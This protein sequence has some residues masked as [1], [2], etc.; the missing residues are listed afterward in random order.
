[1]KRSVK[2]CKTF[3]QIKMKN[4]SQKTEISKLF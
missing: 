2:A 3:N 4:Q 1:M